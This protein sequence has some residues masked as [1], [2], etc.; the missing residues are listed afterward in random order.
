MSTTRIP[1]A[2]AQDGTRTPMETTRTD[3]VVNLDQGYTDDYSRE[4]GADPSAK[5]VE[6]D[7]MNW[8]FWLLTSN[9]KD[10][11]EA[12][13][14]QWL[15]QVQYDVPAVVRYTGGSSA[16]R[17]FRCIARPPV[18][19]IPTN[20]NFWEEVLTDAQS[21]A[22]VAFRAR[23][24]VPNGSNFD[25]FVEGVWNVTDPAALSS[26]VASPPTTVLG[27]LIGKQAGA[28]T[29]QTYF[30]QNGEVWTRSTLG[31][32]W[33]PW[34]RY[35]MRSST[36]AGYGITDGFRAAGV[37]GVGVDLNT[38]AENVSYAARTV[39]TDWEAQNYPENS[40]GMILSY[41]AGT[42][43][44]ASRRWAQTFYTSAGAMWTRSQVGTTWTPWQRM[45]TD[46]QVVIDD[47]LVRNNVWTGTN[48]YRLPSIWAGGTSTGTIVSNQLV[49]GPVALQ[50]RATTS[51][52]H[53]QVEVFNAGRGTAHSLAMLGS[54]TTYG[55]ATEWGLLN[56]GLQRW[57]V[58]VSGGTDE[59]LSTDSRYFTINAATTWDL[60][61][62]TRVILRT[63]GYPNGNQPNIYSNNFGMGLEVANE[64]NNDAVRCYIT[65][66]GDFR[67]SR[68]LRAGTNVYAGNAVF[69]NNG[70]ATGSVWGSETMNGYV[71]NNTRYIFNA[72]GTNAIRC[73]WD[74]RIGWHVDGTFVGSTVFQS[75]LA[76]Y[77]RKNEFLRPD[78]GGWGTQG[79]FTGQFTLPGGGAWAWWAFANDN[80]GNH[81]LHSSGISAGGS[82]L[83]PFASPGIIAYWRIY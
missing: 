20:T 16:E 30:G 46:A 14:P 32:I 44:P 66:D 7:S 51:A 78:Q 10:W 36:L 39:P 63:L 22:R 33:T 40:E 1:Q 5:A 50:A 71:R 21:M 79:N 4:L 74:G 48:D 75:E 35:A 56:N 24:N 34:V 60:R 42:T 38:I 70:D 83:R 57:A 82:S 73:Y 25:T 52:A 28:E 2:F 81:V 72:T 77:W 18:G 80:G 17:I 55:K 54:D 3:G 64:A 58:R 43:P 69:Q 45:L 65:R 11:Q 13:N 29:I 26:S 53:A 41:G 12:S 59:F 76:N 67:T 47:L 62:D 9:L 37:I 19:T 23:G 49:N 31:G 6:R 8:L 61:T 27:Y 68:H 15:A